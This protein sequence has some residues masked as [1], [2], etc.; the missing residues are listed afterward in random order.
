MA[1]LNNLI[2]G[3]KVAHELNNAL[4]QDI[5]NLC[6]N[7]SIVPRLAIILVGSSGPSN[8]YIENKVKAA[9]AVGIETVR[10]NYDKDIKLSDLLKQIDKLNNDDDIN[11]IIVQLP[12]PE[13][14]EPAK[15]AEAIKPIKDVDGFNPKNVGYLNSGLKKGFVPCTA[16]GVYDLINRYNLPAAR[17]VAI[18]GRSNIV[19][20]PLS[21][22]LT[23]HDFTVTICHSKTINLASHTSKADVVVTA[24]GMGKYFDSKYFNKDAMVIDV[25][26]NRTQGN[27]TGD[28]Y[29]ALVQPFVRCITPVPGGVG[30]MTIAYLLKNTVKAARLQHNLNEYE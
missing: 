25:G 14:I 16:L 18:V 15:V 4:K 9:L 22:L 29:F 27:L 3:R 17:R 30:P 6:I 11:G 26:I 12:L 21:A 28:V 24:I 19:G 2:D 23:N 20:R 5:S 8:L 7:Y 1:L 10:F 13:D